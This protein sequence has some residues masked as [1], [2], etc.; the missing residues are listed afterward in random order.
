MAWRC[1]LCGVVFMGRHQRAAHMRNMWKDASDRTRCDYIEG[2]QVGNDVVGSDEDTDAAVE[3]DIV[4]THPQQVGN[5]ENAAAEQDM[6]ITHPQ[7]FGNVITHPLTPLHELARRQPLDTVENN[8]VR[9]AY[10]ITPYLG[11]TP[12]AR[13]FCSIQDAWETMLGEIKSKCND[14]FWK[15]FLQLHTFSGVVI[16]KCLQCVKNTFLNRANTRDFPASRRTLLQK[17]KSETHDFW[18]RVRHTARID[19]SPFDLPSGTRYLDFKFIDPIW[20]WLV[21]ARRQAPIDMH[22]KPRAQPRDRSNRYYGEGIQCG[23]YFRTSY[24][25]CPV[26]CYNMH[27]TLH[28]DGTNSHHGLACIPIAV[29][30]ANTNSSEI[31]TEFCV[32]YMPHA[33]DEDNP[34]Y[35][36]TQACT[37]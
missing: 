16:D 2:L 26:G 14:K 35:S 5:D 34:E 11:R 28:W 12:G 17:I 7:Q 1:H 3:Q 9:S 32:G 15:L 30:V 18:L 10:C 23:D 29:G 19:L 6:V 4:L 24:D 25:S 8:H 13:D 33:P 22:W 31:S 36:K 27:V 21:A 37:R 20:G